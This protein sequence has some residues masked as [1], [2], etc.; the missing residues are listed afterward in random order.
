MRRY[1][2][3][4]HSA[5]VNSLPL[6]GYCSF[7]ER[8]NLLQ[9]CNGCITVSLS[10]SKYI[11]IRIVSRRN[12]YFLPLCFITPQTV[13]TYDAFCTAGI[14]PAVSLEWP[15]LR[16]ILDCVHRY[17]ERHSSREDML[18]FLERMQLASDDES[19]HLTKVTQYFNACFDEW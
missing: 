2:W 15:K 17:V 6:H 5:R 12:H 9:Q 8:A 19:R 7:R 16:C 11:R 14:L 1:C 13:Q 3:I 10:N 18:P 4:G